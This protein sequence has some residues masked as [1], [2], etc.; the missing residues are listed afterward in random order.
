MYLHSPALTCDYLSIV[1][2]TILSPGYRC[3]PPGKFDVLD[4][5]P[6]FHGSDY[7]KTIIRHKCLHTQDI[8]FIFGTCWYSCVVATPTKHEYDSLT[9]ART[10]AISIFIL[11]TFQYYNVLVALT[12][13]V[14][15]TLMYYITSHQH[16]TPPPLQGPRY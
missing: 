5:G 15:N 16:D 2:I 1:S 4:F 8:A 10:I 13:G 6:V 12:P 7:Q 9:I 11:K 14:N 3:Q